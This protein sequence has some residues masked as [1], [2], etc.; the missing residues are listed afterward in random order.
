MRLLQ[1]M[2]GAPVGG[3]ETFFVRLATALARTGIEQR[4]VLRPAGGRAEALRAAGVPVVTARFGGRLDFLTGPRLGAEIRRFKP[5]IVLSWMNRATRFC[6]RSGKS[7]GF[8]HVGT[9]RGYYR[10]EFYSG[11]DHLICTTDDLLA[12]FTGKGWPQARITRIPNFAPDDGD[13]RPVSRAALDTPRDAPLLLALGRLHVNKGFDT[14]LAALA[15]LPEHY[16]W[17]GGSGGLEAG[18]KREA[19]SLGVAQRVRFLG[20]R[21]DTPALFAAADAFVCSSRIEPFGNIVIEAW[22]RRVPVVAAASSGPA[23]LIEDGKSGLLAPLDDAASL[24]ASI[25]RLTAEPELGRHLIQGGR[26]A[27]EAEFTE[28]A[29]VGRYLDLFERLAG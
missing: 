17:L 16:L 7:G 6:P 15:E 2:A 22:S 10:T 28:Q 24:A 12:Y 4:A 23:S 26:T 27:F 18:L 29:V 19:V 20:W 5:D 8:V 25:R 21:D 13:T 3:A 11:C 9:P 1:A 14:L